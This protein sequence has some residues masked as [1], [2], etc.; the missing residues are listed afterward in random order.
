[1]EYL[2]VVALLS[3]IRFLF[4]FFE[5]QSSENKFCTE[6]DQKLLEQFL[7]VRLFF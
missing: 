1:M 3:G 4:C 6:I 5:I 7:K 2:S